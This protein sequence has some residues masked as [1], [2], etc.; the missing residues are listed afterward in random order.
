MLGAEWCQVANGSKTMVVVR[1]GAMLRIV[2]VVRS[3]FLTQGLNG[4]FATV[5]RHFA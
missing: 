4:A 5:S 3:T 1:L 2:G